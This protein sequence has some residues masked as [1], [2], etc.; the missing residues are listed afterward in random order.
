MKKI[1][2]LLFSLVFL[3]ACQN[4]QVEKEDIITNQYQQQLRGNI[5]FVAFKYTNFY[6]SFYMA[7]KNIK[8]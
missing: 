7:L 1:F 8:N 5:C 4:K 3:S 6:M 2:F